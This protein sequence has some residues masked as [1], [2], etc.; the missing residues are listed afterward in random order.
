MELLLKPLTQEDIEFK[1]EC[2]C[3]YCHQV[4]IGE[5]QFDNLCSDC[6][7]RILL[8]PTFDS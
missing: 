5:S 2:T 1:F 3:G 4:F 6:A 8:D 7:L